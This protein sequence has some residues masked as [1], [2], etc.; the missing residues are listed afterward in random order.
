[1]GSEHIKVS[2]VL[3]GLANLYTKQGKHAEA[4]S[5]YLRALR[6]REQH[7]GQENQFVVELLLDFANFQKAQ[8][9]LQ[10]TAALYQQ[11][12]TIYEQAFGVDSPMTIDTHKHLHQIM[13]ELGSTK[14]T[15]RTEG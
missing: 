8:G 13:V 7:L 6:I 4:E 5:L 2:I 1:L 9:R 14:E 10:K 12:L 11:A 15:A 3:K